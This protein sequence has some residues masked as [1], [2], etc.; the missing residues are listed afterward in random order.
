VRKFGI[1]PAIEAQGCPRGRLPARFTR[2]TISMSR[3]TR[4][5]IVEKTDPFGR[6]SLEACAQVI[7]AANP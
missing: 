7:S 2:A 6:S 5:I 3:S 4:W 1:H